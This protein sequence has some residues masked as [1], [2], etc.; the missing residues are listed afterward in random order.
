LTRR[1]PNIQN[2]IAVLKASKT[3]IFPK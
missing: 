2:E 3:K 1:A